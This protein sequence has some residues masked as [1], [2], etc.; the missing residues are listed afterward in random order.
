MYIVIA[1]PYLQLSEK[2]RTCMYTT[3]HIFVNTIR[4]SSK[5]KDHICIII[6]VVSYQS[7]NTLSLL[8]I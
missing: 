2:G 1:I 3:L 7:K 6:I 8:R 4:P 5:L